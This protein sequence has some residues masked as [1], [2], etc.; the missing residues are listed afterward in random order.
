MLH[1]EYHILPNGQEI[2]FSVSFNKSA[3]NLATYQP[4]K[5]G[6]EVSAVPVKRS[7][8]EGF[9]IE[10]YGAFTGFN[11]NLLEVDRQSAKRLLKAIEILHEKKDQYLNLFMQ[12]E[13]V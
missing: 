11:D 10:E 9:N 3:T 1:K 6:Y 5:I 13:T 2:K 8:G 7:K 12:K 4:K